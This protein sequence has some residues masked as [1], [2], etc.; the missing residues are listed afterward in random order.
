MT[1]LLKEAFDQASQLPKEDRDTLAEWF[2]E[3][4]ASDARGEAAFARSHARRS[5]RASAALAE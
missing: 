3:E 2:L 4:L 5:E 1:R